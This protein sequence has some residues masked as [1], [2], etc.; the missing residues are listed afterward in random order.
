MSQS[1]VPIVRVS[2]WE[3][4]EI[5]NTGRY[6]ERVRSGELDAVV[7]HEGTPDSDSEQPPGTVTRTYEIRDRSGAA[8]AHAQAFIQPGWVIGGS[9][10]LDPKRIWKDGKLYRIDRSKS[11]P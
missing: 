8:L 2:K 5:F 4:R 3:L 9:G 1:P 7:I 11:V 10:K 6:W